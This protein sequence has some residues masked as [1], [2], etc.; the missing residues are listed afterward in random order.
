MQPLSR[1]R[2][3][4]TLEQ[5]KGELSA[6]EQ[7][8]VQSLKEQQVIAKNMIMEMREDRMRRA[9]RELP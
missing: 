9:G 4:S 6:L 5:E 7:E 8:V 1:V 2:S 3:E